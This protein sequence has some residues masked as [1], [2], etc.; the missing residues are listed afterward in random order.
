LN[1][2]VLCAYHKSKSLLLIVKIFEAKFTSDVSFD[3]QFFSVIACYM[4]QKSLIGS[5]LMKHAATMLDVFV[6]PRLIS[7]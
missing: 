4:W 1:G 7:C 3:I 2:D 6:F 5:I